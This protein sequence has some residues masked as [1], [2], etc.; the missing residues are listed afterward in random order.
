MTKITKQ[1]HK[2]PLGQEPDFIVPETYQP[3]RYVLGHYGE[4]MLVVLGMNPSKAQAGISDATVNT[5]IRRSMILDD[6]DG[7]AAISIYPERAT[8]V[9]DLDPLNER[10]IE[11]NIKAIRTFVREYHV[12]E[13]WGAWG[14][15]K[16]Q[17][18]RQGRDAVLDLFREE[19]VSVYGYAK[20]KSG[21]PH[22]PL[23]L[24]FKDAQR[25]EYD[26][27]YSNAELFE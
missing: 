9:S 22:H 26:L 21:N 5:I 19:H 15:P 10:L 18:L 24:S 17:Q 2:Y 16:Q 23:Y 11:G 7:W 3:Y 12:T 8:N 14:V 27:S 25:F 4:K 1:N 13:V 6:Y 20:L